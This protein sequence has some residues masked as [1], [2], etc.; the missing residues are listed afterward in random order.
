MD[1]KVDLV[2]PLGFDR[3]LDLK[4]GEQQF[5]A[6]LDLSTT[7][8][9]GETITLCFDMDRAHFFDIETGRNISDSFR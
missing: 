9:E 2:E 5:K 3:E 8:R 1:I 4:L 6:R 7:A